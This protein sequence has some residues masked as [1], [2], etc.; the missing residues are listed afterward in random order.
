MPEYPRNSRNIMLVLAYDGTAYAGW[1][2]Q[3]NGLTVQECLES[4]IQRITGESVRVLCAGRTDAGVHAA[5]QVASFRTQSSI[6]APQ[7][8]AALQSALPHERDIVV[9]ESREVSPDFHAT[10]SAI[11]KTYRYLLFDGSVCPPFLRRYVA[12]SRVRLDAVAMHTAAQHLIGTHDFRC[13]ESHYPNKATSVRTV[14]RAAVTR[15]DVWWPWRETT[16]LS[17]DVPAVAEGQAEAT[18][19]CL[20]FE[21]TA[22]GFLYNMV[23]AIVGTLQEIGGGKQPPDHLRKVIRSLDRKHAG[24]TAAACGLHLIHVEYPPA[25]LTASSG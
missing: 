4:A 8:R 7:F 20:S 13:F 18:G 10:F 6:P 24:M 11:R 15:T 19:P 1:Q 16:Q 12:T 17:R 9:L 5:G 3:P 14:E 21:V 23:R 2:I 22:D 25:L